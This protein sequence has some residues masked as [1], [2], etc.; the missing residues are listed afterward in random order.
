M[1]L[2]QRIEAD[3]TWLPA[4]PPAGLLETNIDQIFFDVSE[5]QTNPIKFLKASRERHINQ[6]LQC[7]SE[8]F[9]TIES[10]PLTDKQRI[11]CVVD[12]D[13]NLVLAGAGTGKT[14]TV[15]G[16]VAYL[17]QSG[18]AQPSEILLLAFAKKAQQEMSERLQS[19]LGI[20]G[21]SVNTFHSMGLQILATVEQGK[22]SIS[23]YAEDS[24]LKTYFVEQTFQQ[25]Q[26]NETYRQ[27]LLMYFEQWLFPEENPF[28]FQS[29]GDYIDYLNDNEIRTLKNEKVKSFAECQIA[30]YLFKNGVEYQYEAKYKI[31]TRTPEFRV[32]QPDFYLPA[33]DI[34]I[35]HF[36]VDRQGNTAP[37]IDRDKYQ[38][39]MVWKR[40]LHTEHKTKLIETFHYEQQ[41]KILLAE[42]EKK[43]SKAGVVFEPLPDESVLETLR[44]FGA[45]TAFS[46][47]LS[48]LLTQYKN[49]QLTDDEL[50]QKIAH[51][52]KP[53]Q[54]QAAMTLLMPIVDAY[55]QELTNEGAI[56]FDD[57]I[58]LAY[59][60]VRD[61][62]FQSRWKYILIDEYQ[63]I[64]LPRAKLVKALRDQQP[65]GSLFCVGDDWQSIYRFT[66][67][68]IH[69][70][71]G[72][73]TFFGYT[74]TTRLDKTFRF[75]NSINEVA[76]RFVL[77]NPT[78]L[79]KEITSHRQVDTLAVSLM[80][81]E[82][83]T[84]L[85]IEDILQS[86]V[87]QTKPG[88]SVYFLSRFKDLLPD[89]SNRKVIEGK[90]QNVFEFR[91]DT[92]HASK[93]KEAD[94]VILLGVTKGKFGLPSAIVTHPLIE[95]LRPNAEEFPHA[96]ER[97]LFYVAL[98]R[99]KH[100]VFLVT[101]MLKASEFIK[102]LI[103][104]DYPLE[105]EEF[106]CSDIQK[107]AHVLICPACKTGKLALHDS[108]H[109]HFMGCSNYPI[110]KHTQ[111]ACPKC[112]S[113]MAKYNGYRQCINSNCK[114]RIKVCPTCGGDLILRKGPYGQFYGCSNY[115]GAEKPS[116]DY[117]LKVRN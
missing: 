59:G 31:D 63:D 89:Y 66:G 56:D 65:E 88:A 43:L 99:A 50:A 110:C 64:S 23:K 9:N 7:Y 47:L 30:N 19:R 101:D 102:E 97:R 27:Q 113:E 70:T 60:Y 104:D 52:K 100:K 54:M 87:K 84:E 35:E 68:D 13:N 18:L 76:S 46:K 73:P 39:G 117:K 80:R 44:E 61:G 72:F 24:T 41:E 20:E 94:Y 111:R 98:T 57:M 3:K 37:Y 36:G 116:C 85:A 45:I 86:L 82:K 34:Y 40:A 79:K 114:T 71:S 107:N 75:N 33:H 17:L 93:G 69:L 83:K 58:G 26:Q 15:V 55:H 92:I 2:Q 106:G 112:Q 105:L 25:L 22:P 42:L 90:Y 29:Y 108:K 95:A 109:G 38:Q 74:Q 5:I 103:E 62:L 16:R 14:S 10:M 51:A 8:L 11:A 81:T 12:D 28:E 77:K 91:Y 4:L 115:R 21:V 48:E 1:A 49:A 6:Q 32:Y 67:S 53:D 78:Q 96:E